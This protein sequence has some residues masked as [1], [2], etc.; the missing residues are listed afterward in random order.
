M[1]PIKLEIEGIN[2]FTDKQ[3]LDFETVG[4]NN[5]FCISGKTGAGKTTIFDCLMLALYGRSG[6]GN[7]PDVVNISRNRAFVALEFESDGDIYRVERVIKCKNADG[8]ET[9]HKS[10]DGKAATDGEP[11]ED[12]KHNDATLKRTATSE[13]KLIKNGEPL[14][15]TRGGADEI[16]EGIVGL[17]E[18]EFKNVYL[19]EQGKYA[20]FLKKTPAKQ[21]ETVGKIFSLMRFADV[22]KLANEKRAE[23]Q[24]NIAGYDRLIEAI[25]E[26]APDVM[27]AVK[28]ELA[29]LR[30]KNAAL[31]KEIAKAKEELDSLCKARDV[32]ISA[33][34]KAA[35][36]K[37]LALDLDNAKRKAAE[38]ENAFAEF[39]K[40]RVDAKAR[41]DELK[42][43]R[44]DAG[45]LSALAELDREY[46]RLCAEYAVK[47]E[48]LDKVTD[49]SARAEKFAQECSARA[50]NEFAQFVASVEDMKNRLPDVNRSD[51]V[52]RIDG[53]DVSDRAAAVGAVRELINA[54]NA[55]RDRF[56]EVESRRK[57][58][59]D[60]RD[61][62]KSRFDGLMTKIEVLTEEVKRAECEKANAA[63]ILE[64]AE[65]ALSAAQTESYAAAVRAE[66]GDGD[67]CPVC[68]GTYHIGEA[69]ESGAGVE[70]CKTALAAAKAAFANAEKSVN[71]AEQRLGAA[72]VGFDNADNG[73]KEVTKEI[74]DIDERIKN[75]GY[76]AE[77]NI[78]LT[79]KAKSAYERGNGYLQAD[80]E[81]QRNAP[82]LSALAAE[83]DG[84]KTAVGEIEKRRGEIGERLGENLGKTEERLV[85]MRGKIED[86]EREIGEREARREKL[87]AARDG[88]RAVADATAKQ[89]EAAQKECPV[90]MPEFD[91]EDYNNKKQMF[92]SKQADH[93]ER[94][95][96]IAVKDAQ[97][98]KL[99][100]DCE[101]LK[102]TEGERSVC[103]RREKIFAEIAELTKGKAL[104]NFVANE[105]IAEF[106]SAASEILGTLS[107]GKY[108][109][110]YDED[111]GFTVTDYLN[112]GKSRKTGT[113]S[114]GELFL[115]SLSVAIAIARTQSKGNNA[116][117]FLDE[118]FGTLD[119][120][121]IDTVFGAL[122]S[123]SHDCLVGV[124]SHSSAL[125]ERMPDCVIVEEASGGMGS[126]ISYK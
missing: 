27:H 93:I 62:L 55:E 4:R 107:S 119:E 37:R 61:R 13:C 82:R 84:V 78:K 87:S 80:S 52:S 69:C 96:A 43:L 39:E 11:N 117:F 72:K 63:E 73:L 48:A 126:R 19:L 92:E 116:F 81:R 97:I 25:G 86:L 45:E 112:G 36:V 1:K 44:A 58:A 3:E 118:G 14:T 85:A 15:V 24:N 51:A 121:L 50:E 9:K 65:R 17:S 26:D 49:E 114:G 125:I 108:S 7:L 46:S 33:A 30:A 95:K 54:L 53:I 83:R 22:F 42:K 10:D 79:E 32:Y 115:A 8:G 103:V 110:N 122:E 2:S 89:L 105:Y 16:L 20:D 75:S 31:G 88:D 77:L 99:A 71:S 111:N 106:A 47:C 34:E 12:I 91:E 29:A 98:K 38:S 59:C 60:K 35:A 40:S 120:E 74:A 113:L 124:I 21:L 5:L 101:K 68:G 76:C 67:R 66:L 102:K 123:L 90:D 94:E 18:D 23:E 100:E 70:E 56:G 109:I 104:L 6:K 41:E 64:K 57:A 28:S